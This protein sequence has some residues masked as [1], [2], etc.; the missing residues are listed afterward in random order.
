MKFI[1]SINVNCIG[2]SKPFDTTRSKGSISQLC[3]VRFLFLSIFLIHFLSCLHIKWLAVGKMI[4][5]FKMYSTYI[6][7]KRVNERNRNRSK[8]RTCVRESEISAV[9]AALKTHDSW[10]IKCVYARDGKYDDPS[11]YGVH[12]SICC[13]CCCCCY[14]CHYKFVQRF[15]SVQVHSQS[16]CECSY[17]FSFALLS[18]S[19]KQKKNTHVLHSNAKSKHENQY[20]TVCYRFIELFEQL[21]LLP[22]FSFLLFKSVA[23]FRTKSDWND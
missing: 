21:V 23:Y 17:I 14:C 10:F 5:Q 9:A 11:V 3:I 1:Y 7:C 15:H 19:A 13:C 6:E 16:V 4:N 18:L 2:S 20:A 12:V 8:E 22:V